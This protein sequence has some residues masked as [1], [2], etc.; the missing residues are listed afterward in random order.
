MRGGSSQIIS[1]YRIH[2]ICGKVLFLENSMGHMHALDIGECQVRGGHHWEDISTVVHSQHKTRC[3][4]IA[5]RAQ[6]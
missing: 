5:L 4:G 1:G 2:D 3:A 6:Y